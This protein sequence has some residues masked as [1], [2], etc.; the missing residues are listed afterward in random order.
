MWGVHRCWGAAIGID[1]LI[2][3]RKGRSSSL[4]ACI[5][6]SKDGWRFH[7]RWL[8]NA[9]RGP[10]TVQSKEPLEPIERLL[11]EWMSRRGQMPR[12]WQ[13]EGQQVPVIIA[14]N[15]SDKVTSRARADQRVAQIMKRVVKRARGGRRATRGHAWER[16]PQLRRNWVSD[17]AIHMGGLGDHEGRYRR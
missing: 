14:D 12:T 16:P 11:D 13:A 2:G 1:A 15:A 7:F 4:R 3:A 5:G 9:V 6:R 10:T 17:G 8:L